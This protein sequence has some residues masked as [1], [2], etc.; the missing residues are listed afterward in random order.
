MSKK[1]KDE[2]VNWS[3]SMWLVSNFN[4]IETKQKRKKFISKNYI[5]MNKIRSLLINFYVLVIRKK[6]K[7]WSLVFNH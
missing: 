3:V 6:V 4:L 7:V 1:K 5:F 2:R